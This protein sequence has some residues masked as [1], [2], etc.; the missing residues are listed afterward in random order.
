MKGPP[1]PSVPYGRESCACS[2]ASHAAVGPGGGG[3]G[4]VWCLGGHGE[5]WVVLLLPGGFGGQEVPTS[6]LCARVVA[7][8]SVCGLRRGPHCSCAVSPAF[9]LGLGP[10]TPSG[11]G[12][13]V[14]PWDPI[15]ECSDLHAAAVGRCSRCPKIQQWALCTRS[16]PALQAP[17]PGACCSRFSGGCLRVFPFGTLLGAPF[18][19]PFL[20]GALSFYFFGSGNFC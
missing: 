5:R 2:P 13:R 4:A 18:A 1:H 10:S 7:L 12:V 8:V 11:H 9:C 3:V 20:V 14:Q 16:E 15:P 6:L 17:F 19:F